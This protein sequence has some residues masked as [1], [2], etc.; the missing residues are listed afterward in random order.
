MS[1]LLED[2]EVLAH[3]LECDPTY[4][5]KGLSTR[6]GDKFTDKLA[7]VRAGVAQLESIYRWSEEAKAVMSQLKLEEI[8]KEL[9]CP[10]GTYIAPLVLPAIQKMKQDLANCRCGRSDKP[11]V[12]AFGYG[13]VKIGCV[14]HGNRH[15]LILTP[16]ASPEPVGHTFIGEVGKPA[17]IRTGVVLIWVDTI[18]GYRVLQD[19]VNALLLALQGYS[20]VEKKP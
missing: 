20:I 5:F 15:G 12:L 18:E 13:R 2:L 6:D 19:A 9:D 4:N 14:Q 10:L 16:L 11:T 7:R 8:G 3:E 1:T 17:D